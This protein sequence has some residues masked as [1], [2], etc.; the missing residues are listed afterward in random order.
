M[1]H[2]TTRSFSEVLLLTQLL[3]YCIWLLL[4]S[5][6]HFALVHIDFHTKSSIY[7]ITVSFRLEKISKTI[8]SNWSPPW[9]LDHS[10]TSSHFLNTWTCFLNLGE[11]G[12]LTFNPLLSKVPAPIPGLY[13]IN[14]EFMPSIRQ[15][16]NRIPDT[17][18]PQHSHS[19]PLG[20]CSS[21]THF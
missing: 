7:R 6:Q 19:T 8:E 15:L 3:S 12:T 1:A 14:V 5:S 11:W 17:N 9:Q 13:C 16:M 4:S 20:L 18:Q 10:A 21:S 2:C